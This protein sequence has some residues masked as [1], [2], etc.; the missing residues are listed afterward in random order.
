MKEVRTLTSLYTLIEE[1]YAWRITELSNYR[2]FIIQSK[3]KSKVS[4]LRGGVSLLYAHWE[5]FIKNASDLYYSFVSNQ[6]FK[7]NELNNSFI[8]IALRSQLENLISSKKLSIHIS[9]IDTFFQKS[10]NV[11]IFSSSSPIRTSNLKYEIFEDVCLMLGIDINEF[12]DRYKR[13]YD[14][15]IKLIIDED[16]LNKRNNIAHGNFLLIDEKDFKALYDVVVNG[17]LY[18][19]KELLMDCAQNKKYLKNG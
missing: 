9:L 13:R 8:S 4:M 17:L 3:G 18:N 1:D 11:P 10:E 12:H 16:L 6:K 5:G 19:F 15:N 14:R 2:S 7:L